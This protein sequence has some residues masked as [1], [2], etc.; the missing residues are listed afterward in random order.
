MPDIERKMED[1]IRVTE[2]LSFLGG[3]YAIPADVLANACERGT[4]IH[5]YC[6]AEILGIGI[7]KIRPDWLGYFDSFL[8]W[9]EGKQFLPKPDRLF[10]D[11]H[12]ITGEI[13]GLYKDGDDIVLFDFKT[14][15]RES[16]TWCLQLS[17][18]AY[19]LSLIDIKVTKI[20]AV[21]LDKSGEQPKVYE[22][23]FEFETYVECLNIY[24]RFFKKKKD[25][26]DES[27]DYL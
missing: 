8:H 3:F 4:A 25:D 15:L 19:L 27:L 18:Y 21:K 26:Y 7:P 5:A 24:K 1:Y 10:C 12:G 11:T 13:D 16:K 9:H 14:P 22:Y 17:A 20:M 23:E 2:A 6:D